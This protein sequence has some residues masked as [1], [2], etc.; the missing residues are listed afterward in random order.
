L[1]RRASGDVRHGFRVR[2]RILVELIGKS[3]L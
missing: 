3:V 2:T 1:K